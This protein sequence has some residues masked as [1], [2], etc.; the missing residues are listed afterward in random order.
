MEMFLVVVVIA[1]DPRGL[2]VVSG[3]GAARILRP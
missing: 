2:A 3:F 1:R